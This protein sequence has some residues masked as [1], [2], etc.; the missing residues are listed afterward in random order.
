MASPVRVVLSGATGRMGTTLAS[1]MASN[2][3]EADRVER[4][5]LMFAGLAPFL[6]TLLVRLLAARNAPA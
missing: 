2:V 5:A 1:L 6:V 4:N 3:P